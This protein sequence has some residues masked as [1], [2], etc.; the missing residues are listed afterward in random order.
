MLIIAHHTPAG[1]RPQAIALGPV[2]GARGARSPCAAPA[3]T[4][5]ATP[6]NLR[7]TPCGVAS[8]ASILHGK[9]ARYKKKNRQNKRAIFCHSH[10]KHP[11]STRLEPFAG[12]FA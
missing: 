9:N 1:L 11:A 8:D 4:I 7:L 5:R 3:F 10:K 2:V 12:Y 6:R